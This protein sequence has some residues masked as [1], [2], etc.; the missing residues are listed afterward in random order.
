MSLS[1]FKKGY[2]IFDGQIQTI[3][4][5]KGVTKITLDTDPK[6]GLRTRS[7]R[8]FAAANRWLADQLNNQ[9]VLAPDGKAWSVSKVKV[10]LKQ[11]KMQWHHHEDMTTMQLLRNG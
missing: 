4:G 5:I 7:D 8:D 10:Y 11:Q 6:A 2:P 3:H 9:G 1:T